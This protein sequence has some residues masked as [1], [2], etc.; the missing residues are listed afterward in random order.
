MEVSS[1]SKGTRGLPGAETWKC[2]F[3]FSFHWE[4]VCGDSFTAEEVSLLTANARLHRRLYGYLAER[5]PPVV[6]T[7]LVA[8]FFGSAQLL[9]HAHDAQ[10]TLRPGAW[11]GALV[12]WLAFLHLRLMDEHKDFAQDRA[13]YPDRL[14]SR[15]VVTLPLLGRVLVV[16]VLLELVLASLLGPVALGWWAGMFLFTLAMRFEFGVGGWLSRHILAYA[17]TH[18]PVVGLLAVFAHAATGLA[19]SDRFLAYV[20]LVSV[21]SLAFEVGRKIRQPEE[22]IVGVESYS[23]ALGRAGAFGLLAALVA[24]STAAGIWTIWPLI[25]G[26]QGVCAVG[27]LIFGAACA[28]ALARPGQPAKRVELGS[29]VFLLLC[30]VAVGVAAW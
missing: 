27:V 24:V 26:P 11:V 28:V 19:W 29:S 7:V 5:F 2:H 14:L 8:L 22:E 12:V 3:T 9:A 15:G 25:G 6:Y 16:V 30:F 21:S 4:W 10:G 17:I 1:R 18:N 23:S 20:V 13:A